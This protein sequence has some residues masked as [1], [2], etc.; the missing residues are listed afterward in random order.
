MRRSV[1]RKLLLVWI[2]ALAVAEIGMA[3]SMPAEVIRSFYASYLEY[4]SRPGERNKPTLPMSADLMKSIAD[5]DR[6]CKEYATGVCGFGADGDIYLD[7]QEHE[8]GL[9]IKSSGF[10]MS[11]EGEGVVTVSLN[12]YPSVATDDA[13]YDKRVTFKMI[14]EGGA[15]VVDDI[16]YADQV[17]SKVRM[18]KENDFYIENP[19]PDSLCARDPLNR[20]CGRDGG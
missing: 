2:G 3:V 18:R 1:V 7:S 10:R 12:V 17:S 11:I 5:N 13:F 4:L 14:L 16:L 6:V 20:V 8:H 15:W 9:S 19:D